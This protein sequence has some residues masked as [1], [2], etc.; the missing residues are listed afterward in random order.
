MAFRREIVGMC[1]DTKVFRIKA[2]SGLYGRINLGD[3]GKKQVKPDQAV[4]LLSLFI[5]GNI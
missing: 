4:H 3:V 2:Y 5:G 1:V